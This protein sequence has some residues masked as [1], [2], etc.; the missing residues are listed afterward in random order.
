MRFS[1]FKNEALKLKINSA[2]NEVDGK[3]LNIFLVYCNMNLLKET[4]LSFISQENFNILNET[5][6]ITD[7]IILG[8]EKFYN[9]IKK[10]ENFTKKK[11]LIYQYL[12]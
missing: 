1:Y 4:A 12:K 11:Y 10:I 9:K 5:L 7:F 3:R 6:K 8:D 2:I